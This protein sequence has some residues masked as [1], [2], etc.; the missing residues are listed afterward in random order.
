MRPATTFATDSAEPPPIYWTVQL[1]MPRRGICLNS[2]LAVEAREDASR[3][4]IGPRPC[5]GNVPRTHCAPY[6]FT[7]ER[8]TPG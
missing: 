4:V 5:P 7:G 3:F 1:E 2:K 6:L 8:D